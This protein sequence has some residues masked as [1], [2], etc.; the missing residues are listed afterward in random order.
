MANLAQQS[1][2]SQHEKDELDQMLLAQYEQIEL[3]AQTHEDKE[4]AL[5]SMQAHADQSEQ[6]VAC[7]AM[8][9]V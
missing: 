7:F 8:F 9:V 1:W 3:L 6:E 5:H 2:M 4:N